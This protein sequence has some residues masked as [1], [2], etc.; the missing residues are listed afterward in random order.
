MLLCGTMCGLEGM[1]VLE[2]GSGWMGVFGTGVCGPVDSLVLGRGV[3]I[4]VIVRRSGTV[5]SV[6][7]DFTLFV[8]TKYRGL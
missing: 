1:V 4:I 8:S 2:G 7:I 3:F 5:I 6:I